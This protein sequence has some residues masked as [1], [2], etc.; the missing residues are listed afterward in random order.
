MGRL[1]ALSPIQLNR[2]I[3]SANFVTIVYS[4]VIIYTLTIRQVSGRL[5][6]N[7][8]IKMRWKD[9][10]NLTLMISFVLQYI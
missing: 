10:K 7:L 3:S 5:L 9:C 1:F 8:L 2:T 6:R 4:Q